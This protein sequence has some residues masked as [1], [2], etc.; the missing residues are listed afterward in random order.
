MA[1]ITTNPRP[2]F[3]TSTHSYERWELADAL[4]SIARCGYEGVEILTERRYGPRKEHAPNGRWV[5]VHL[6]P[7]WPA[8]RIRRVQDQLGRLGL[9][10]VCLA[11]LVDFLHPHYGSVEA[12]IEEI[13]KQVDLAVTLGSPLVRPYAAHAVPDGIGRDEAL[14]RLGEALRACGD[15][16][17]PRGV[18]L[19]VEN[20][21]QFSSQPETLAAIIAAT[22]HPAVG[23]C[24]HIPRGDGSLDAGR[25]MDLAPER[26]WHVHLSDGRTKQWLDAT[27]Y[28]NQGLPLNEIAARLGMS[29]DQVPPEGQAIGDGTADMAGVIRALQ[30]IG[31][32]GWW[33]HEGPMEEDPEDSERRS[34]TFLKRILAN[35]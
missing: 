35:S 24:L 25:L 29:P 28:R 32:S 2:R 1:M 16:A 34:L 19:V 15:Y 13:H 8:E 7:D 5:P 20:H 18:R 12:E 30:R 6:R 21:G 31:Y 33:N 11:P 26:I 27:R 22:D 17:A 9:Q 10:V 3:S 14:A 4:E 23:I